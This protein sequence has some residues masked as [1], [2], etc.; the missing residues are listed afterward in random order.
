M[1][2]PGDSFILSSK[3]FFFWVLVQKY[4]E[5]SRQKINFEGQY[6][7]LNGEIWLIFELQTIH[8][9]REIASINITDIPI[10]EGV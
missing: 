6:L 9:Q 4:S 8:L 2:W 3:N 5:H 10:S 1:D 7:E